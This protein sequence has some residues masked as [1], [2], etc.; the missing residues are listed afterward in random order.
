MEIIDD[1]EVTLYLKNKFNCYSTVKSAN[2]T[3]EDLQ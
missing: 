1:L 2:W 3:E